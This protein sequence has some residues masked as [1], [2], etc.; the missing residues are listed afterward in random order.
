[1]KTIKLET[2]IERS[3]RVMQLEGMFDLQPADKA[4]TEVPLNIPELSERDWS[5]GL[6]VGPSGAGKTTIAKQMFADE[7]KQLDN[8]KWSKDKAVIDDFPKDLYC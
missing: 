2:T 3:A 4:I 1:M 6:I 8:F 7:M 5:I